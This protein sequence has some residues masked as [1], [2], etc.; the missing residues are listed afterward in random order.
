[1]RLPIQCWLCGHTS[2]I[3][4]PSEVLDLPALLRCEKCNANQGTAKT[5]K[6]NITVGGE[7]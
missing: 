3:L 5:K 2:G 7:A 1:M 6:L 4:Q